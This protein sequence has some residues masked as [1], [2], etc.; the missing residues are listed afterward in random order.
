MYVAQEKRSDNPYHENAGIQDGPLSTFSLLFSV[1]QRPQARLSLLWEAL[2]V[3]HSCQIQQYRQ[4]AE[5]KLWDW[6]IH[7][8]TH[9]GGSCF[10]MASDECV[11]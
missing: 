4:T 7:S 11:K 6:A 5:R 1:H 10:A 8:T 9:N 2:H 3:S